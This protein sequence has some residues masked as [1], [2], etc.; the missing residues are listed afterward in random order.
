MN[1]VAWYHDLCFLHQHFWCIFCQYKFQMYLWPVLKFSWICCLFW[2]LDKFLAYF[3]FSMC[4]RP[5]LHFWHFGGKFSIFDV[6]VAYFA[7]LHF[8]ASPPALSKCCCTFDV[9]PKISCFWIVKQQEGRNCHQIGGETFDL[10][11][12]AN[13]ITFIRNKKI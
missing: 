12:E 7:S 9:K 11:Y 4:L 10:K 5:N 6:F 2:I 8:L 1:W 3:A 13:I